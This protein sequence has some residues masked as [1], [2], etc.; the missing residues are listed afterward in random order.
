MAS[1]GEARRGAASQRAGES[2]GGESFASLI[3]DVNRFESSTRTQTHARKRRAT[4]AKPGQPRRRFLYPEA[5]E[6][7]LGRARDCSE[8]TLRKLMRGEPAATERLDLHGCDRERARR[9]L[10]RFIESAAARGPAC[11]L[12]IHGKG[13]GS[14][15]AGS[16]LKQSLPGWLTR[17]PCAKSVR[18]FAPALQRDGGD[19][20]TYVLVA[21]TR[22]RP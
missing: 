7:L 12:V 22:R 1:D 4:P 21:A 8:R 15:E 18:A 6:P 3:G 13:R 20:A 19:G 2:G 10:Q 5:L 11:L 14:G 17:G 9:Q 16:V